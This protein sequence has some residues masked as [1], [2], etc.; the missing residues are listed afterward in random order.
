MKGEGRVLGGE[1]YN[2]PETWHT[3]GP[4]CTLPSGAGTWQVSLSPP[5]SPVHW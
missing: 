4:H 2:L 1:E 5:S 3:P